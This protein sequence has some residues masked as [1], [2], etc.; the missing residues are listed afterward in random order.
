MIIGLM[1]YIGSG[2]N[3]ASD[4]IQQYHGYTQDSFAASLKDACSVIFTW[5]R[6]LLEGVTVESRTFRETPDEWWSEKL[7][8]PFSP[9]YA[10]QNIGTEILRH[11]F[12]NDIWLL[13]LEK[14]V[15]GTD[16][17]IVI[18][19]TRFPNEV[20]LIRRLGGK[21]I[22]VDNDILPEWASIAKMA[23]LGDAAAMHE[24][25]NKYKDVHESE[26]AWA[27]VV[28]DLVIKNTGSLGDLK[29]NVE[30]AIASIEPSSI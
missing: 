1:G 24:M 11:G 22:F 5:P 21:I 30:N 8:K 3:T 10:L 25:R 12:H 16:A 6:D 13:S 2:K 9:R 19:D 20:D 4:F 7:G 29:K 27:A 23:C 15:A 26:W 18:T 28:P 14:R 17:K